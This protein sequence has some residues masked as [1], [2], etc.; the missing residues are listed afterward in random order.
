M[1][2][3]VTHEGRGRRKSVKVHTLH[4]IDAREEVGQLLLECVQLLGGHTSVV[5]AGDDPVEVRHSKGCEVPEAF[6]SPEKNAENWSKS[7][8]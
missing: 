3:V 2:F 7:C 6:P 4:R 5:V 1:A 8:R